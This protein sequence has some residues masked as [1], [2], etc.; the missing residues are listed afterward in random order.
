M[1][2]F[3]GEDPAATSD[4]QEDVE[5]AAVSLRHYVGGGLTHA[6]HNGEPTQQFHNLGNSL[7]RAVRN[8]RK[9]IWINTYILIKYRKEASHN[10]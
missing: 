8:R 6:V 9:I 3:E 4:A 2:P 1:Y 5:R 7:L 10:S